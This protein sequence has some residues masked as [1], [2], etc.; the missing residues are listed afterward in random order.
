MKG[1]KRFEFLKSIRLPSEA[2]ENGRSVQGTQSNQTH[3]K[4]RREEYDLQHELER[5]FAEL[6]D[7][8]SED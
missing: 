8:T 2:A 1:N 6:F 5:R 4:T 3:K 7:T